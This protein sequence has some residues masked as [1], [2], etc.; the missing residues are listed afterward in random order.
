MI[1]W[2]K[3][4]WVVCLLRSKFLVEEKEVILVKKLAMREKAKLFD[5][6]WQ[7]V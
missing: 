6:S 5:G 4:P 3:P 2:I 7:Q 1:G